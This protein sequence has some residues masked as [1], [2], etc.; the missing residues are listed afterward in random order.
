MLL[1]KDF[2]VKIHKQD[3]LTYTQYII[4][5]LPKSKTMESQ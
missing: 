1:K 5:F 2:R 3:R 4:A